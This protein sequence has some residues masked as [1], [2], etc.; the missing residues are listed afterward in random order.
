MKT[1]HKHTCRS[2]RKCTGEFGYATEVLLASALGEG[3]VCAA[4][5]GPRVANQ[6]S[7]NFEATTFP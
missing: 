7:L 1:E 5:N 6:R 2:H 3:R 4:M